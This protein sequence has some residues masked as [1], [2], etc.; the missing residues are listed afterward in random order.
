[1]WANWATGGIWGKGRRG[2]A[3]PV[4][5]AVVKQLFSNPVPAESRKVWERL[6][7]M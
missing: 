7:C 6:F 5:E 2:A 1:M 3:S 4:S